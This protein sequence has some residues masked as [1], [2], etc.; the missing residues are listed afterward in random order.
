MNLSNE[1]D[2]ILLRHTLATVAYRAGKVLRGAPE[3]FAA[4][5][6]TDTSR[7]PSKILA[8][9]GDLYDWALKMAE[10]E[11]TWKDSEP[12]EWNREVG[13]F[14]AALKKFDDYLASNEPV[15]TSMDKLFQGPIADSL[16]HIGQVAML[17]R[18][19][20]CPIKGENYAAA[21]IAAGKVGQEQSAPRREFD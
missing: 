21:D 4:F 1:P 11:K 18:I 8:H 17:R 5:K 7:A 16:A 10:G 3:T 14:F 12:Q 15:H 20:G 13:R 9:M 19:A 6:A 2:R